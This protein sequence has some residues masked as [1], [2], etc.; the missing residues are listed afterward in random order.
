MAPPQQQS[1][2][3]AHLLFL[4]IFSIRVINAVSIRTFFQPDE[5]Y[6]AL[7]P[8]WKIAFGEGWVTW[9]WREKL[10]SIA[11]PML[12][13]GLYNT[14]VWVL[15]TL[16]VKNEATRGEMLNVAPRLLQAVFAAAGD[17]YTY[18]L[19]GKILGEEAGWTTLFLSL[20]SA[21]HWFCSTRTFSNSLETSLTVIAL[22]YWP[23]PSRTGVHFNRGTLKLALGLAAIACIL[24]PT[25]ALIWACLGT[26]LLIRAPNK[27]EKLM[28]ASEAFQTGVTA[29]LVNLLLDKNYYGT[30]TFPPWNFL[31]FNLL[32]SLSV[33]YGR[34][35]WHYYLTQGLPLLLTFYAPIAIH[36][37]S[38]IFEKAG[39]VLIH[40]SEVH[41]LIAAQKKNDPVS[42]SSPPQMKKFKTFSPSLSARLQLSLAAAS[43]I[44]IYSLIP[45]KELRFLYPLLPIFLLLTASSLHNVS[46]ISPSTR[47]KLVVFLIALNVPIAWYTTQVHQRGVID[48]VNWLRRDQENWRSVGFLM[49]C[50]STPWMSSLQ[51][52][53][54]RGRD[55]WALTCEPPVGLSEEER[56]VY[57]DEADQ[58]YLNPITFLR[59]NFP[60]PP[61]K[62][63]NRL[64]RMREETKY[65]W[66]D[67]LVFF[68]VLEQEVLKEYLGVGDNKEVGEDGSRYR[69]CN[70]F[71]NSHVHEDKRRKGNVVVYCLEKTDEEREWEAW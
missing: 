31:K 42:A 5:Y 7:E 19:G 65:Q 61:M 34:N 1:V 51:V 38:S 18:K 57:L 67:R 26:F 3:P 2:L 56:K 36:E 8:A 20:G 22:Y 66:P 9:E 41:A 47:K 37:I 21:F 49:P 48:V 43:T 69:P 60:T 4:F 23:W 55:M 71:F 64:K 50:H 52:R 13:A 15:D 39:D 6:Q 58:F 11:H 33:F 12:F 63:R 24:R 62:G 44:L 17:V 29:I 53:D 46:R 35:P 32:Q 30:L 40:N 14:T 25:N 10:R 16:G 45:H 68:Q 28:V 27:K 59:E 54:T 70:R